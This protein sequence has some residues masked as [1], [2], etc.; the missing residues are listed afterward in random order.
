[1][2]DNQTSRQAKSGSGVP[3]W[4]I[5]V[6]LILILFSCGTIALFYQNSSAAGSAGVIPTQAAIAAAPSITPSATGGPQGPTATPTWTPR[7]S[8]TPY[9]TPTF[10]NTAVPANIN[11]RTAG[12]FPSN[13]IIISD[14][15]G[16]PVVVPTNTKV[17]PRS[18]QTA[19]ALTATAAYS[20]TLEAATA[21]QAAG[22]ATAIAGSATPLPNFWRG[23]YFA[24]QTLSDTPALV[25]N[26]PTINFNWGEGSPAANIPTDHFS[27]RWERNQILQSATYL[28]YAYSDDGIRV[29]VDD[30]LIIDNWDN[31]SNQ[32]QY[33]FGSASAGTHNFR[34]E[35]YENTGTAQVQFGWELRN[36]GAWVGEYYRNNNLS[37]APQFIRQDQT[38]SFNW[39]SG[40]PNGLNQSDNFSIR[41]LNVIDFNSGVY[42]FIVRH[43]D[44]VIVRVGD[45]KIIDQWREF[46]TVQTSQAFRSLSGQRDITV[47]YFKATGDGS[48]NLTISEQPTNIGSPPTQP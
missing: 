41:W 36:D 40:G 18:T 7:A 25:R 22:A 3:L 28:F 21:T 2:A 23:S 14:G 37:G 13:T 6:I 38:I 19:V 1:M 32:V 26:D 46:D 45:Q 44:G 11:T 48:I 12:S 42:D 27:V 47:E 5:I 43:Q 24:N 17:V 10:V 33:A 34:V 29:Y 20:G 35:Y 16:L 30:I 15:S 39:G 4:L 9:L 31:P 8:N